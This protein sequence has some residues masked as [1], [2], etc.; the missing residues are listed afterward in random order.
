[1]SASE[2]AAPVRRTWITWKRA[3]L[4]FALAMLATA[5]L[6]YSQKERIAPEVADTSRKL[7]GDERTAQVES[8][9]FK[10]E[11]RVHKARYKLFGGEQNP[12]ETEP[13]RV[14][15][16]ARREGGVINYFPQTGVR[17]DFPEYHP[18]D[19][20][21]PPPMELP[22]VRQL[23]ANS[24]P[25]EG[26]WS[27]AGLPLSS[28]NDVLMAKTFL[29]P[30]P[31][32][33][34]ALVGVLLVDHRRIQLHLVA[35]TVDPGGSRNVAGP[36]IIPQDH[37]GTL[38]TAWNGGFKGD[39]GIFGMQ[40]GDTVFKPL[41]NNLA[42]VC[43]KA[44]GTFVLGE[45]GRDFTWD[46]TMTA[47]RQNAILL[48]DRGEI[49]PRTNEGNDTW[50]YVRVDSSEFITW[51]SAIGVTRGGDLLIAAGN[52]L[53]ADTLA[54]ALWAAGA[55]YA[56]QLDINNPYVLTGLYF[57]QP[58]G[59]IDAERF[60]ESMPDTPRRFLR[61]N[62]RDFMYVTLNENGYR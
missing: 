25:G 19:A 15:Y 53:S 32:R 7:I 27:T 57:H 42:T 36:G 56:M 54:K 20:V 60:M 46:G 11:D 47:C 43:T 5:G 37:L 18:E 39:H 9:F 26:A 40:V 13:V 24:Q 21:L 14:Q 45:Y 28:P 22:E 52:S 16:V 44:D 50:G 6:A 33:P 23:S 55:E 29:R 59:S 4:L 49:S 35:G 61:T 41:R 3:F 17:G 12:F 48:V 30:D 58:D 1:M 31:S 62:E 34:Y 51:R 10:V 2:P 8:W 38:L